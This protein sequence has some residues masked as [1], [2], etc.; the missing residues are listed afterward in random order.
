[1]MTTFLGILTLHYSMRELEERGEGGEGRG[2]KGQVKTKADCSFG[3]SFPGGKNLN[4]GYA[5]CV[6]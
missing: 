6:V 3:N 5:L 4:S 2:Q 1:M